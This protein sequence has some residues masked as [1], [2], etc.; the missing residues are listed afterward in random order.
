VVYLYIAHGKSCLTDR[1]TPRRRWRGFATL[2]RQFVALVLNPI[3]TL[4]RVQSTC[5][6]QLWRIERSSRRIEARFR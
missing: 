5:K 4:L 6:G 2:M 1:Q 3:A